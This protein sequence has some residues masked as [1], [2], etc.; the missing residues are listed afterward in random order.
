MQQWRGSSW[1][2]K[3]EIGHPPSSIRTISSFSRCDADDDRTPHPAPHTG[4][5]VCQHSTASQGTSAKAR[6][7]KAARERPAGRL[8]RGERPEGLHAT[9]PGRLGRV[10]DGGPPLPTPRE[11][12]TS[13]RGGW[14]GWAGGGGGVETASTLPKP[15]FP[16]APRKFP[17]RSTPGDS[18][19]NVPRNPGPPA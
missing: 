7:G 9:S 2:G 19:L 11:G 8:G 10:T 6:E 4:L 1:S 16:A 14:R 17:G 18:V 5:D 12:S 13:A 15:S 3:G